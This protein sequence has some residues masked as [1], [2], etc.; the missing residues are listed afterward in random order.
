LNHIFFDIFEKLPRVGPGSN[1]ATTRAFTTLKEKK[2]LPEDLKILDIGCG[3]GTHTLQL[4]ELCDGQITALDNHQP[5]L[6][7]LQ[8]RLDQTGLNGKVNRV[9]G[10]MK[11]MDFEPESF[12]LIWS[13]GAIFIMGLN[14]GLREWRKF[15]KPGGGLVLTDAFLFTPKVPKELRDFWDR[16]YPGILDTGQAK[17]VIGESGY[18]ILDQFNLPSSA[19]WDSYYTPLEE[20]LPGFRKK[21]ADNPEG[22]GLIAAL[23]EEAD[24]FRK[25][26]DYYGYTFFILER[27]I[28]A[29]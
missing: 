5:F 23:Q 8:K 4:A 6:D 29:D 17:T 15:L 21:Y 16:I 20:L 2:D 25:Y 24:I 12:D 18:K 10:D 14:E 7:T 13:E 11:A 1:P 26:S 3:T 9:K 22:M 27:E 19:W 28:T